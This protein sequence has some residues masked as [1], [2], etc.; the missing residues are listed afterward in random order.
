M[1]VIF[2]SVLNFGVLAKA[3]Q[4]ITTSITQPKTKYSV[5]VFLFNPSFISRLNEDQEVVFDKD[6]LFSVSL[7]WNQHEIALESFRNQSLTGNTSLSIYT[8]NEFNLLAYHYYINP[9]I[10]LG[11]QL[12]VIQT[13]SVLK[14]TA[15]QLDEGYPLKIAYG[16]NLAFGNSRKF[17]LA[18]QTMNLK[19]FLEL[20]LLWSEGWYPNL[21]YLGGLK[22]GIYF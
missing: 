4:K 7:S 11:P 14:T 22:V 9:Y 10:Y 1:V 6:N 17:S 16:G 12:G 19:V 21:A 3:N 20:K 13:R 18:S 8:Q 5:G 15:S 2:L